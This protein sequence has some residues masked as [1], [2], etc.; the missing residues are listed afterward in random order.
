MS[1][2]S[3]TNVRNLG[4]ARSTLATVRKTIESM[5][6][7][8]VHS[9]LSEDELLKCFSR[10]LSALVYAAEQLVRA[11]E[12]GEDKPT[13]ELSEAGSYVN[14][15]AVEILSRQDIDYGYRVSLKHILISIKG[16]LDPNEIAQLQ[17]PR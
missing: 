6:R 17:I 11:D 3:G 16:R 2:P 14:T 15:L 12:T 1:A 10:A 5:R 8:D 7:G 4:E 13:S 9:A